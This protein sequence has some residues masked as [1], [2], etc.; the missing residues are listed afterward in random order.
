MTPL[1]LTVQGAARIELA[2]ERAVLRFSVAADGPERAT[3]VGTVTAALTTVSTLIGD[4]HDAETGPVLDWSADQVSVSAQRPWTNDG[5]Q[6][7]LVHRASASGR[8]TLTAEAATVAELVDALSAHPPVT[9]ESLEWSLTDARLASARTEARTLAVGDALGRA[10]VLA[11]AVGRSEVVAVA[12]A[13]PGML[14][15]A[16]PGPSPMPRAEKMMAM[17]MDTG[18][19]GFALRPQPIVI[20]VAVDARFSA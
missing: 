15:G 6:A 11:A 16:A 8:A 2:P 3:V 17:A 5:S 7:P 18:G 4:L 10:R 20:E 13:D 14:D 19:G 12:L 1:T 9:I